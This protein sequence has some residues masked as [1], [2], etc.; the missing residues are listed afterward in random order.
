MS[1]PA[2]HHDALSSLE[3]V[4][5]DC[6][7]TLIY[8]P[9]GTNNTR[10]REEVLLQA[11]RDSG[12]R[13]ESHEAVRSALGEGSRRHWECWDRGIATG[14]V[15]VVGWTLEALRIEDAALAEFVTR[16]FQDRALETPIRALGGARD[17]LLRL[18]ERGIRRALVCDT[19]FTPAPVVRNLLDRVQLL[20]LLEVTIF[21]D[22]A[23]VPKP[24]SIVFHAALSPLDVEPHRAAHVGDLLR[25]DVRGARDMGMTS[26]RIRARNDD[27]TDSPEADIVVDSHAHLC[28]LL[29]V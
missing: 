8:Q 28:E 3:A 22:E 7:G 1:G 21:S 17:T 6:W 13:F 5:F 20:D 19:G 10:D 12:V 16:R 9:D 26:V 11:L 27:D 15:E 23:G 14:A 25:T 24:H 29:G 18:K 4:T 2:D